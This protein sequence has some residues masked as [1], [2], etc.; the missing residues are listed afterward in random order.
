M[1]TQYFTFDNHLNK[2]EAT[3][4]KL[5]DH[6]EDCVNGLHNRSADIDF[7]TQKKSLSSEVETL[8]LA[9]SNFFGDCDKRKQD[10]ETETACKLDIKDFS[11]V[12]DI[13]SP[14]N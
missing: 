7:E 14:R 11:L 12:A 10:I 9:V 1:Q 6:I 2:L 8:H 4:V 5:R 13:L 3:L